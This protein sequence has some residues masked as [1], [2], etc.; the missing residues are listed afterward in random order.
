MDSQLLE[1]VGYLAS[2][3][4]ALSLAISSIVKFRWINLIGAFLFSTYGFLIGAF[5]VFILNGIIV[6]VDAYYLWKIYTKPSLFDI[7]FVEEDSKYLNKFLDYYKEDIS[8]LFPDFSIYDIDYNVRFFVLR[9]MEV[10]GLFLANK[11]NSNVLSVELD[12]V[13]PQYR[14]YKNGIYVYSHL[15]KFIQVQGIKKI[16]AI[17]SSLQ[18]TKYLKKIGFNKEGNKYV[19]VLSKR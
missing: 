12:Y 10:V 17:N 8:K 3:L 15:N 2:V 18:H 11:K 13:I 1:W 9:N 7:L 14:D 19:K 16:E 5:P 6:F 4:V